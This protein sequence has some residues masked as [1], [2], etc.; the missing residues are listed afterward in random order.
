MITLNKRLREF[1]I[2]IFCLSV[3]LCSG[4]LSELREDILS[5]KAQRDAAVEEMPSPPPPSPAPPQQNTT[6][7]ASPPLEQETASVTAP[8]QEPQQGKGY[9]KDGSTVSLGILDGDE[10][11]KVLE[12]IKRL[13]KELDKEVEK[14]NAV[15]E[16]LAETR[17]AK[18]KIE[19]EFIIT[20][21]DLEEIIKNLSEDIKGLETQNKESE[22]KAVTANQQ[23]EMLKEKILNIQIAETKAQQE[24]YKLK[25]EKLEEKQEKP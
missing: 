8:E 16:S 13:E 7:E 5:F 4:C 3:V 12:K 15:E 6:K 23:I 11:L 25:I 24:L 1:V 17:A 21:R 2:V 20:K 10:E 9:L 19:E 22:E 18:T 14:R